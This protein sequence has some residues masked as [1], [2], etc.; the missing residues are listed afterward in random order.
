MING[1][2]TEAQKINVGICQCSLI[3][4]TLFLFYFNNLHRNI[5]RSLVN[6]YAN[7]TT[8]CGCTS[9]N[10]DD[11]SLAADLSSNL[12]LTAL[13][14]LVTFNTSKTKYIMFRHH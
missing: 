2:S 5:L 9:K 13:M 1:H 8:V 3:D 7:D 11:Q 12:A 4:P 6:T 14:K 10:T